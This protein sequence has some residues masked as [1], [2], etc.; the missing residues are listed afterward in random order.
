MGIPKIKQVNIRI[1]SEIT[2][3][4]NRIANESGCSYQDVYLKAISDY[5]DRY[6]SRVCQGCNA[7]NSPD[8]NFCS[9]CGLPMNPEG[10][11]EFRKI[12]EYIQNNPRVLLNNIERL[13]N[14]Q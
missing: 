10:L 14:L 3:K 11:E 12:R 2:E 5:V 9:N 13:S 8:S 1:P 7:L 6:F 4:I